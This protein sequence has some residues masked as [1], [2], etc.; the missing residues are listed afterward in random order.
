ME[1]MRQVNRSKLST[2]YVDGADNELIRFNPAVIELMMSL[3]SVG[4][5]QAELHLT[6]AAPLCGLALEIGALL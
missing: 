5:V 3:R 1:R 4:L 2:H 6:A